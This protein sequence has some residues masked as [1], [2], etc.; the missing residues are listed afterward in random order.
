M[1]CLTRKRSEAKGQTLGSG[2]RLLWISQ[3]Q[4]WRLNKDTYDNDREEQLS[5]KEDK[6]VRC[7]PW[8]CQYARAK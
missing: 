1:R 8:R 3:A 2:E 6:R 7:H 5:E 4:R